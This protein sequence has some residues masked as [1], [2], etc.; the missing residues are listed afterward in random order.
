MTTPTGVSIVDIVDRLGMTFLSGGD[1]VDGAR[2]VSRVT[3]H[4]GSEA[5]QD[6]AG[7]VVLGAGLAGSADI[8]TAVREYGSA[9]AV[10]LIV[11]E[12]LDFDGLVEK[13]VADTDVALLGMVKDASWLQ[14]ASLINEILE[15]GN[16]GDRTSAADADLFDLAN[17]I[18]QVLNGPV[19]IENQSSRILAFSADQAFGD[20]AR[21]QSVLGHQVPQHYS[22]RLRSMG[23]FNKIYGSTLPV[24]L[25]GIGPG[26]RPRVGMRIH[27]ASQILGSI[28]VILD[29]EP[30]ELQVK[31]LFEAAGVAAMSLLR[32][33]LAAD[34]ARR[35]RLGEVITLLSGGTSAKEAAERLGYGRS[36]ANV[37]AAGFRSGAGA[38]LEAEADVDQLAL[39]LN[40]YLDQVFPLSVAAAIG[41]TVYAVIPHT[42][43]QTDDD[44]VRRIASEFADRSRSEKSVVIGIGA[45]VADVMT[46]E[47]SRDEADRALRVLRSTWN[48]SGRTVAG[49]DA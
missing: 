42:R 30:N 17:S 5:T 43:H 8:A 14:S 46:L 3:L 9:G 25:P 15:S 21:K 40:T 23:Y 24:F 11:K 39:T 37:L 38:S 45:T 27:A 13:A 20:E 36:K 10:A 29:E 31:T 49:A 26:I 35:L 18:A 28:W 47:K 7:A 48:S 4:E 33:K 16:N 22:D 6:S 2:T 32:A 41:G 12:P 19:T 44:Y 34:S 1:T